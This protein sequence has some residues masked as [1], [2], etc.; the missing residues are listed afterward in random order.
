LLLLLERQVLVLITV[1]LDCYFL[2]AGLIVSWHTV[3]AP[4]LTRSNDATKRVKRCRLTIRLHLDHSVPR[5]ALLA[6]AAT[7]RGSF[8]D[9]RAIGRLGSH[10]LGSSGSGHDE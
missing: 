8:L 9:T 4:R 10:S 2:L 6:N 3:I 1:G 7:L 5:I